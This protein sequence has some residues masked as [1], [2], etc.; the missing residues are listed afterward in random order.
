MGTNIYAYTKQIYTD[1]IL[2]QYSELAKNHDIEGIKKLNNKLYNLSEDN[3]IHIGKSSWGW[4]FLFNHNNW[5]YFDY[6]RESI[7]NFL[8][9]CYKIE[10][11]YGDELSIE[12]FWKDFVDSHS[13]GFSGQAYAEFE[14]KRAHEKVNKNLEDPFDLIMTIPQAEHYYINA[15]EYN[16]YECKYYTKQNDNK[17]MQV[18]IPYDSFNYRFSDSIYFS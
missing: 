4:K 7:N 16:W 17:C 9:S 12:Q 18:L 8:R 14:L 6:S 10:T 15:K 13:N 1:E 11:E 5:K 3:T 2:N